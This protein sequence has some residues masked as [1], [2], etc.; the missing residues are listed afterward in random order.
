MDIKN[1]IAT[2][3]LAVTLPIR[4]YGQ[5][6]DSDSLSV[7]NSKAGNYKK[8]D[9]ANTKARRS[10]R[11][12]AFIAATSHAAQAVLT[13]IPPLCIDEKKTESQETT[14][15]HRDILRLPSWARN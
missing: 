2:V 4:T 8:P 6:T 10:S 12:R 5:Q 15:F 7:S 11:N 14:L 3:A 1:S 9:C 13:N